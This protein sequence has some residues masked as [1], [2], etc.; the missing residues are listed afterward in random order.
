VYEGIEG[1]DSPNVAVANRVGS[2]LFMLS[3]NRLISGASVCAAGYTKVREI[4]ASLLSNGV[5]GTP[6]TTW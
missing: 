6:F 3:L 1:K 2:Q 4:E 5:I